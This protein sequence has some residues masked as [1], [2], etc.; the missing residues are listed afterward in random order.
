MTSGG[1]PCGIFATMGAFTRSA[2]EFAEGKGIDLIDRKTL[3]ERIASVARPGENLCR[4]SGW[5]E[6][7]ARHSRIFDPECPVCREPMSLRRHPADEMAFW[8]CRN[9]PRC[10]GK[11]E[12]RRDILELVSPRHAPSS[13]SA[14]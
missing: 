2:R 13:A 1:A 4:I 12:P 6:E 10:S 8:G 7:F 3:E 14:V 5:I 11:R 9:Y